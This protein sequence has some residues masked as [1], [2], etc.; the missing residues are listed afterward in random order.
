M[1]KLNPKKDKS[2]P[3]L[4]KPLGR[5]LLAEF[6]GCNVQTLDNLERLETFLLEAAE[7]ANATVIKSVFHPFSPMGVTGVVV[8]MESHL[9]IHTWPE[10]GYAAVDIFTCGEDMRLQEAYDYLAEKLESTEHSFQSIERG[11]VTE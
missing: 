9:S 10:H 5:H 7:V 8:V 3:V 11:M 1:T 2:L 6:H 4:P